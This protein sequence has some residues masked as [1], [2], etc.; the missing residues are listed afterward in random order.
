M[1]ERHDKKNKYEGGNQSMSYDKHRDE[2]FEWENHVK[3]ESESDSESKSK[4]YNFNYNYAEVYKSGN[5]YVNAKSK[6]DSEQDSEDDDDNGGHN[7]HGKRKKYG[8]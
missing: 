8:R 1:G 7:G 4:N 6:V 5:S 3:S 2:G